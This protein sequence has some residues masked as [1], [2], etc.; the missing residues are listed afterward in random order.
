MKLKDYEYVLSKLDVPYMPLNF[1]YAYPIHKDADILCSK[2]HY[3]KVVDIISKYANKY[4][5]KNGLSVRTV[6]SDYRI[7]IRIEYADFLIYQFDIT[8]KNDEM[9]KDFIEQAVKRR[10][11]KDDVFI[12]CVEDEIIIREYEYQLY[13]YKE[14]HKDYIME[15]R[16]N[17]CI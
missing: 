5:E 4:A 10:K 8:Y 3:S 1:P 9:G 13:P 16:K 6:E 12:L 2:Y 11:K 7:K 17:E 15:K 14:Y